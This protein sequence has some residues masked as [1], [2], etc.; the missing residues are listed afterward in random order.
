MATGQL[1]G[2]DTMKTRAIGALLLIILAFPA[3][4]KCDSQNDD[5]RAISVSGEAV[6]NVKPDKI[7]IT[8]G[9]ETQD[10]VIMISK[11]KNNDIMK[12]TVAALEACGVPQ[13]EM[14]TDQL[15]IEPR[16]EQAYRHKKFLGYFVRNTLVVTLTDAT[17]IEEVVT[18]ALLSGV[19]YI[20]G[21]DFQTT[22]FKMY[23][24]QAREL[25]LEAAK[26][27]AV[28]MA[29]VLGQTIGEPTNI[30]ENS[31]GAPE[32][33]YSNW[34]GW[35]RRA[36]GM[37]QTNVQMDEGDWGEITDTIA[38]GKLSIRSSVSVTFELKR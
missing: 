14:Q 37:A 15:S 34:G 9:I 31:R 18:N 11:Q 8:F 36:H 35:G 1:K 30:Y 4:G 26:E 23:R 7:V 19:N 22:D 13:K 12:K 5:R 29:A 6:V 28:K 27:K 10:T 16:W 25:A 32:G 20:H 17:K 2:D 21:V 33:Y 24:E 3:L 38:L